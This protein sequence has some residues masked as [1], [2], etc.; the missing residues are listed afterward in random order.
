MSSSRSTN[1]PL[2]S[3]SPVLE[4]AKM[5][6]KDLLLPIYRWRYQLTTAVLANSFFFPVLKFFPCPVFNCYACPL[7][8]FACPIGTLQHFFIIGAFPFATLGILGLTG[9][10]VGRMT[11]G[12][13]CPFGYLQDLLAKLKKKKW[14]IPKW[15]FYFRY[16]TLVV[17][18]IWLP[19]WLKAPWFSKLC[20]AGTLQAGIPWLLLKAD[21][22]AQAGLVFGVKI[23]ILAFF[24]LWMVLSKRPFCRTTCP[25]GAIFSLFNKVSLIKLEVSQEPCTGCGNCQDVCPVEIDIRDDPNSMNCIRCLECT[26]CAHVTW[27][28]RK[29]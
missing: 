26:S 13:L 15:L 24:L 11:C 5:R 16:A 10:M 19:W 23:A 21:I 8:I 18:V 29:D 20:P 25:L 4:S 6:P 12:W 14:V 27:G 9:A 22:R 1:M 17:L 28:I 7:A 2:Y 3:V